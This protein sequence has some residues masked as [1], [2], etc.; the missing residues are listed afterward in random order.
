MPIINKNNSNNSFHWSMIPVYKKYS[1]YLTLTNIYTRKKNISIHYTSNNIT[2]IH[3]YNHLH[4]S[5]SYHISLHRP[6]QTTCYALGILSKVYNDDSFLYALYGKALIYSKERGVREANIG[7]KENWTVRY[8]W[9]CHVVC[10]TSTAVY[11]AWCAHLF[12]LCVEMNIL[13]LVWQWE[14]V[15]TITVS[16]NKLSLILPNEMCVNSDMWCFA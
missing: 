2:L 14:T 5:L 3:K 13:L 8:V 4:L 7:T 10:S 15:Y 11:W 6:I 16:V 1:Y 12:M 9:L